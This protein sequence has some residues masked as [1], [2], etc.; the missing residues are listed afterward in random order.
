MDKEL[1]VL[2]LAVAEAGKAIA[3]MRKKG[4]EISH[5]ANH[6]ILTEADL[7]ADNILKST[8]MAN[9]PDY[10]WLSEE[11][12]GD[13]NRLTARRVW[14]IDPIDGT[15]EYAAGI[16]EYAVSAALVENGKPVLACVYNPETNEMFSAM[17][18]KGARLNNIEIRCK[19]ECSEKLTLLASNSEVKRGEWD[20]FADQDIKSI[21]SIAYKLALIAAGRADATFSLGPK[22]EWDIAAGVLLVSEAGGVVF[23]KSRKEFCFNQENIR[24][25]GI[26]ASSAAASGPLMEVLG[27]AVSS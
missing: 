27:S 14:V 6:D 16:P 9:F 22:S 13:V 4:V 11:S 25:N 7:H 20:Q 10:G 21:G 1:E 23:D 26:I 18:G 12:A 24:V 2:L 17:K 19:S 3:D 5:K 15:K 8:L